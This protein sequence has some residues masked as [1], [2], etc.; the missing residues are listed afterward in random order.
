MADPL[1]RLKAALADR[2]A[3]QRELGSGGMATVYLAKDL[4]LERHVAIKVVKPELAAILGKERFLREV[5]I[6][7]KLEHPHIPSSHVFPRAY[8]SNH[9]FDVTIAR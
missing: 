1:D 8:A 4:K 3:V 9:R 2:Y 6:T 7:A 5:K